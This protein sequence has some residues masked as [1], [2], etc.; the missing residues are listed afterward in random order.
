MYGQTTVTQYRF[1]N[2]S[3]PITDMVKITIS[4]ADILADPIIGTALKIVTDLIFHALSQQ[5]NINFSVILFT[6]V[7]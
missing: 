1:S 6:S 3:V 7:L 2:H 4:V 5:N